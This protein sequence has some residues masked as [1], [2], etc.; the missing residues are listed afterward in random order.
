MG[1]RRNYFHGTYTGD[2]EVVGGETYDLRDPETRV[3]IAG[4]DDH[5]CTATCDGQQTIGILECSNP[6]LYEM[7]RDEVPGFSLLDA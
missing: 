2:D 4:F 3:K 6:V 7:C 1:L 5:L